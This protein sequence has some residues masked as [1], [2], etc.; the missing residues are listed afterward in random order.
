MDP[1]IVLFGDD[2]DFATYLGVASNAVLTTNGFC[3]VTT[4]VFSESGASYTEQGTL[5]C[6]FPDPELII[7]SWPG[8]E[9]GFSVQSSPTPSGPWRTLTATPTRQD[10]QNRV[11][12]PPPT[13]SSSSGWPNP[14]GAPSPANERWTFSKGH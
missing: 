6:P 12:V 2:P 8:I 5:V 11:A 9:A 10:G 13:T 1:G 3:D 14:S 4:Q 7:L